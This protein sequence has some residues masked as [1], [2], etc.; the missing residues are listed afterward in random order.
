MLISLG[1]AAQA[2]TRWR[3]A[4]TD[5][6]MVPTMLAAELHAAEAKVVPQ[7]RKVPGAGAGA[8]AGAGA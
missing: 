2:A 7:R 1:C 6:R 5:P 3:S 8:D 4:S